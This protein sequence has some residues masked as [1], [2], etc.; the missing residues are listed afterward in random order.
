[1]EKSDLKT[2]ALRPSRNL[3]KNWLIFADQQGLGI[4]LGNELQEK[5]D[6]V[7]LVFPGESYKILEDGHYYI[8]PTQLKDFQQLI[9][10]IASCQEIIYLWSTDETLD[11]QE[12]QVLGCGGVLHLVQSLANRSPKLWLIN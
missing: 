11:L 8:N 5:G 7:S 2:Q 10:A 3:E 9:N 6:R 1:M 12:A 4:K